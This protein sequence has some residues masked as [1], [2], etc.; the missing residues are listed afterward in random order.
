[1]SFRGG[2]A[3]GQQSDQK[4]G[5]SSPHCDATATYNVCNGWKPDIAPPYQRRPFPELVSNASRFTIH[6]AGG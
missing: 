2:S 6:K 5:K 3:N 1:M 4:Q